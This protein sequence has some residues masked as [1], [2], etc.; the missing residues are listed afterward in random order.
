MKLNPDSSHRLSWP[1]A[2]RVS[3]TL[4]LYEVGVP[5]VPL[6]W[7]RCAGFLLF[8]WPLPSSSQIPSSLGFSVSS[9]L[10]PVSPRIQPPEAGLWFGWVGEGRGRW[11]GIALWWGGCLR[12]ESCPPVSAIGWDPWTASSVLW[13]ILSDLQG[14]WAAVH[15]PVLCVQDLRSPGPAASWLEPR[16]L[17]HT[18][19]CNM[20]T[21]TLLLA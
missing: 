4:Q 10:Q 14:C 20:S 8:L 7:P 1:C 17:L 21:Y 15:R 18:S 12:P 16:P 13:Q 9:D 6:P 19:P 11:I 3:M 2:I 5:D